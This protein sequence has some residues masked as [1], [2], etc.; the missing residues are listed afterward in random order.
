VHLAATDFHTYYRPSKCELRIY[1]S[2][3][4]EPE[5]DPTPFELV[6]RQLGQRHERSHLDLLARSSECVD[7]GSG[8]IEDRVRRTMK[9]MADRVPVIY[10]PVFSATASLSGRECQVVGVPDF[11]LRKRTGYAIRDSKLSRRISESAHPEIVYQLGTYGWLYEQ[12]VGESPVALQIHNGAG[13]IVEL[14]Y[15]GGAKA[16]EVLAEIVSLREAST[17]PY[18]PVGWSKCAQCRFRPRCWPA[19]E[20]R[21]DV[22]LIFGLDQGSA[23]ALRDEGIETIDQ[24]LEDFG[25]ERL[26]G[27]ER[28]WGRNAAPVGEKSAERIFAQARAMASGSEIVLEAPAVP[29]H[30]NYAMFDLEGMPAQLDELEKVYL[31]GLQVFGEKPGKYRAAVATF[32]TQGDREG[33]EV[34]LA[35]AKGIFEGYGDLP[36]V[37]WA[38]YEPAKLSMYVERFGDRDGVAAR[39]RRNLLDLLPV[40]RSALALPLPSYG[41]KSVEGFVGFERRL[42]EYGGDWSMARYIEAAESN[43]EERRSAILREILA[44]NR[45]D[46][47]AT[48]A[49]L[50]WLRGLGAAPRRQNLISRAL[51]WVRAEH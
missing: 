21:R 17:E 35:L 11:L 6:L 50:R 20:A 43:D 5:A 19:A 31:W 36:F 8:P 51:N 48:W 16:L 37:H 4:G 33:W 44:Y 32:G 38:S 26:A 39:V 30:P 10:Q 24:L 9:A 3:Q 34:F 29:D 22:S 47:E 27:L 49:V 45:E 28:S 40:V 25:Q 12:A 1:L 13:E 2:H 23:R 42:E 46:L 7:I 15:D 14:P 18:S 41:L